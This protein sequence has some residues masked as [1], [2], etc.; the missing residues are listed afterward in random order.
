LGEILTQIQVFG[1]LLILAGVI[2]LRLPTLRFGS[3]LTRN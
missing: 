2:S 1:S 3:R